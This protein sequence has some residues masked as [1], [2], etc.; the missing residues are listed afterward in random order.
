MPNIDVNHLSFTH[1]GRYIPVFEDVS[2]QMDTAW[3]LGFVGRNGRG[4]TT[5]L[6]LLM[7]DFEYSG[8]ISTKSVVFE[9]FPFAVEHPEDLT[10]EVAEEIIP[11]LEMWSLEKELRLL[12][13]DPDDILYRPYQTL[14]FGEQT[15]VM[16][17]ILFQKQNGF[18]LIDEPTNHLDVSGR[19]LVSAYLKKKSGFILVSHDRDFLNE[20]IDHVLSIEKTNIVIQK[21]NFDSWWE[22]R[23]RHEAMEMAENDKLKRDISRLEAASK[24]TASWSDKA[25]RSKIG[26]DPTKVEKQIS[27]RAYEGAKAKKLMKQASAIETRQSAAI[28]EKKGL[29]KNHERVD[30][31]KISQLPYFS[32]T[33]VEARDLSLYYGEKM[34]VSGITFRIDRGERV[35][36]QG[37]NGSGKSTL[38]HAVMGEDIR[39]TGELI[40][41]PQL[42][43][44][45]VSQDTSFLEGTIAEY[46]RTN[47]LDDALFRAILVKLG[48]EREQFDVDMKGFSGGQK[49]KVLL[50][51]SLATPAHIHVWDEPMN[52]IDVFSRMQIEQLIHDYEPTLLFVEHDSR[53]SDNVATKSISL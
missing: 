21:G 52:F 16:L 37:A 32:K 14:S 26:F 23:E 24:R 20:C 17:A 53:F 30:E 44:S 40:C 39:H 25:E 43:I 8:T 10:Y 42:K 49:K 3:H 1:D 51:Q 19:K 5:F 33:Y 50:A 12:N 28:E 18:L 9:Y 15:K 2:F 11:E 48:V 47:Q 46:S 41:N 29:L 36:I 13:M 34:V 31:L 35:A 4:K 7:G 38:L 6:K 22:N 27:R 45:F